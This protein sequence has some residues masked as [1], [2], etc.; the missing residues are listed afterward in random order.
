MNKIL[1]CPLSDSTSVTEEPKPCI[2]RDIGDM[3]GVIKLIPRGKEWSYT[4]TITP[5]LTPTTPNNDP[6]NLPSPYDVVYV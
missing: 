6:V 4:D 1:S 2:N 5:I 3:H